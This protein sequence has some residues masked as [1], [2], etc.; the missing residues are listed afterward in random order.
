MTR[1]GSAYPL[2]MSARRTNGS[3]SSSLLPTPEANTAANGG[4][5][6]PDKR[7]AGGHSVNLHDVAV[8]ALLPTPVTEPATGNGHARNLGREAL[9]PTPSVAD[10]MGGHASRSGDRSDE[11]LLPGLVKTLLPTPTATP[12]GNN[13]SPSPGAAVRPQLDSIGKLLPTPTAMDAHGSGGNSP[14]NV[15]LTDAVVRTSLGASTNPRFADGKPSPDPHL[16]LPNEAPEADNDS[17]DG[18][19]NG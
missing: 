19:T 8:H 18:S 10:A 5:Q 16:H 17:R 7:R 2:P 11:L 9:L 6:H 12:Y 13:Q 15:T 3:A 14:A 4:P 1:S